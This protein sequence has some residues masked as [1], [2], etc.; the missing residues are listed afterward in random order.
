MS[1]PTDGH[2]TSNRSEKPRQSVVEILRGLA[3]LALLLA[4][5]LGMPA[6]LVALAQ[7]LHPLGSINAANLLGALS[8]PDDGSLFLAALFLIGWLTWFVFAISVAVE[9]VA[10]T[11]GVATPRLPGFKVAQQGAAAL[12]ATSALLLTTGPVFLAVPVAHAAPITAVDLHRSGGTVPSVV[13]PPGPPAGLRTVRESPEPHPTV[14][15]RRHDTL[16]SLAEAHLG[17]GE[18]FPEIVALN[19]GREQSDGRALDDAGWLY[20]GWTLRLPTG[21]LVAQPATTVG[22][23]VA[24]PVKPYTVHP[25]DTLSEIAEDQ[26]GDDRRYLEVFDLNRGDRQPDGL[27]LSDPDEIRAGWQL[28]MPPSATR[29]EQA[30]GPLAVPAKPRPLPLEKRLPPAPRDSAPLVPTAVP[31]PPSEQSP[32][33]TTSEGQDVPAEALALGLGTVMATGLCWELRRRR[34][35]QQARRPVGARI[36]MPDSKLA[37]TEARIGATA[38]PVT[39]DTVQAALQALMA[40]CLAA[41]RLLPD[42]AVIQV[43]ATTVKLTLQ[44]DDADAVAPFT[45][46][47]PRTWQLAGPVEPTKKDTDPYPALLTLGVVGEA[48][49]LV[50]LESIGALRLVGPAAR[51]EETLRALALDLAVSPLSA[52]ATLTLAGCFPD[53]ARTLDPG[54][55]R[56]LATTDQA[57]RELAVRLATTQQLLDAVGV[58]DVRSARSTELAEEATVP[59][60]VVTVGAVQVGPAAWSGAALIAAG[61]HETAGWQVVLDEGPQARLE[62]LGLAFEPHRASQDEVAQFLSL[63]ATADPGDPSPKPPGEDR[64]ERIA[65]ANALPKIPKPVADPSGNVAAAPRVLVLGGVVVERVDDAAMPNRRRRMTELVAYLALHPGASAHEIDAALWPGKRVEKTTRNPFVS[66]T[67]Q[68]LGRTA[69]GEAYLPQ[70]ADGQTYRLRPEVTC[71][72]HDF[73]RLARTGLVNGPDSTGALQAALDLVRSRPFLGVDPA[74]YT[75]AEADIQEMISAIVDVAHLLSV[76]CLESGDHRGAQQAAARGLLAEPCSE[77]LYRDAIRAAQAAGDRRE[78]DRLAES[79]RHEIALLDPDEEMDDL[80]VALLTSPR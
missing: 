51:V 73:T 17:A 50:N 34:R 26:L 49:L 40:S 62:P 44:H 31:T 77:L 78:V 64:E 46:L 29:S 8:R 54:R 4:L 39:L 60:I 5:V 48:V 19:L 25:G 22:N 67:R 59:E 1:A 41:G 66:R 2:P 43:S 33:A 47:T 58:P 35:L 30:T 23:Q 79:L 9:L 11:R 32:A 42:V 53:L 75:W 45:A 24:N 52:A 12:V 70:I 6:A 65:V 21:T 56:R 69:A 16:W 80:T 38:T 28:A 14:E 74:S 57:E 3:A 68:W 63:L 55:A 27:T 37:E 76:T 7:E 71:D 61:D 72:W 15:V 10:F 18:R 20:P 13:A 36:P